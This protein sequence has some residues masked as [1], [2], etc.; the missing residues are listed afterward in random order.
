MTSPNFPSN[1]KSTP[2][3]GEPKKVEKVITSEVRSRPKSLGTRLK[4]ALIGGDSKS[5]IQYV[6]VE[7]LIPQAKDMIADA[8]TQG[9]ERL[10]FGDNRSSSRRPSNRTV[11]SRHTNYTGYSARG[12]RPMGSAI[13]EERGTVSLRSY[14]VDELI[15]DTR[16]D[17]LAVL[18][19]MYEMLEEF[20]A[21]SIADVMAMIEKSSSH[22]DLKWGWE[23]LQ[24]SDIRMVRGGGYL[25]HLPRPISLD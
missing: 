18:E 25:L 20:K 13:R 12:N 1:S 8:A 14:E 23:D 17:A 2:P 10:I 3:A 24:G 11:G 9:F 22:T 6:I 16:P 21:V 7:V 5:V 4:Q 19:R 15:F